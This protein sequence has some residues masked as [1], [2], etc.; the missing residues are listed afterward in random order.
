MPGGQ[1][2]TYLDQLAILNEQDF[3]GGAAKYGKAV[4][5][6]KQNQTLVDLWNKFNA[7]KNELKTTLEQQ[8][9]FN[10]HISTVGVGDEEQ[11]SP[12]VGAYIN[13]MKSVDEQGAYANLYQPFITAFAT[14][15]DDGVKIAA[16]LSDELMTKIALSGKKDEALFRAVEYERLQQDLK[17][18][19]QQ[20]T[21]N[22]FNFKVL[23][24]TYATEKDAL[25]VE[26]IVRGLSSYQSLPDIT[27][28]TTTA[29]LN[30]WLKQRDAIVAET[31][32][33]LQEQGLSVSEEAL[34]AAFTKTLSD[35]K[36]ITYEQPDPNSGTGGTTAST[37]DMYKAFMTSASKYYTDI[38]MNNPNDPRAK[39]IKSA[40]R[41]LG[42]AK[43][44]KDGNKLTDTQISVKDAQTMVENEELTQAEY[45]LMFK[46]DGYG[47]KSYWEIYSP[48]GLFDQA[49]SWMIENVPGWM[50]TQKEG[51]LN[52]ATVEP[53]IMRY[54]GSGHPGTLTGE[55]ISS[56]VEIE[57]MKWKTARDANEIIKKKQGESL[58]GEGNKDNIFDSMMDGYMNFIDS[59]YV[60]FVTGRK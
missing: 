48:G 27:K 49:Q 33:I 3:L 43:Y 20:Y 12:E 13:F 28:S 40:L 32:K 42:Q 2:S 36:K 16:T 18:L 8:G 7:D 6:G 38:H 37:Y 50:N 60:P 30:V 15:G 35:D 56:T 10:K 51:G 9:D 25:K 57:M 26:G 34:N 17:G 54:K 5:E 46:N 59:T 24:E 14:L 44:D 39:V 58:F 1:G 45:D 41:K 47:G 53:N 19:K 31:K 55:W 21:M 22:D 23:K 29:N 4:K 11:E 52:V